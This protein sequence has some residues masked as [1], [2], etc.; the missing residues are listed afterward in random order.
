[1]R[2]V[3]STRVSF[4]VFASSAGSQPAAARRCST[5]DT[6]SPTLV[7]SGGG[8]EVGA[9]LLACAAGAGAGVLAV[10]TGTRT[11]TGACYR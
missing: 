8:E 11:A 7:Y 1:M 9:M 2:S 5:T 10:E 3:V 4:K 6:A